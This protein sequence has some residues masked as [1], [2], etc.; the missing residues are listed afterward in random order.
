MSVSG[1]APGTS[2]Q[3]KNREGRAETG[4]AQD[5]GGTAV[6]P[7]GAREGRGDQDRSP[8]AGSPP[9][10]RTDGPA[11]EDGSSAQSHS[12]DGRG[13]VAGHGTGIRGAPRRG[14]DS[15]RVTAGRRVRT[16]ERFSGC[17][18]DSRAPQNSVSPR[19]ITRKSR[20]NKI[21]HCPPT[22][23]PEY[24]NEREKS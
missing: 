21:Y 5:Q 12:E 23:E 24:F 15:G 1:E 8:R 10:G 9:G 7:A 4:P 13:T 3:W 16:P 2:P 20:A 22:P 18:E 6:N 19:P 11:P 14:H 17:T